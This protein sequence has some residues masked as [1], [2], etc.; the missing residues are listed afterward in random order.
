VR[1]A[2]GDDAHR[3]AGAGMHVLAGAPEALDLGVVGARHADEHGAVGALDVRSRN[4]GVFERLPYHHQQL[5]LLRVHGFGFA[6][7]DA[8]ELGVEIAHAVDEAAP[9]G[10]GATDGAG[11]LVI[12]QIDVPA[13]GRNLA[14]AA[15]SLLQH[16]PELVGRR[17]SA[18]QATAN[19]ND[20]QRLLIAKT[21]RHRYSPVKSFSAWLYTRVFRRRKSAAV[22]FDMRLPTD[23]PRRTKLVRRRC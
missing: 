12:K 19:A 1:D 4:A 2:I 21:L 15:A 14:N 5:A 10:A 6:R 16:V 17:C 22:R 7:R 13:V 9:L 20:R 23:P 11:V 18:R 3:A 8:E